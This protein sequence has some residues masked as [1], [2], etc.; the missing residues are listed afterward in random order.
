MNRKKQAKPEGLPIKSIS[1]LIGAGFSAPKG[2][3]VGST[4]NDLLLK[5]NADNFGFASCGSLI[6]ST[7]EGKKPSVGYKTSYDT[8]FEFCMDLIQYF[9]KKNGYFDYE[10]FYDFFRYDAI[11]DS[12]VGKVAESYLWHS[13]LEQLLFSLKNIYTQL[14]AYYLKDGKGKKWYDDEPYSM[15][16]GYCEGYTGILKYLHQL[17]KEYIIN[18][19]SLNHDLLFESFA[20]TEFMAGEFCDGFEQLGSPYY[21]ALNHDGRTYHVRLERYTGKYDKRFRLHKLHGSRDY[22]VYHSSDGSL[23]VPENYIKTR[24]GIGFGELY[25]EIKNKEGNLTYEECWIN[26]HADF[27]TGTT[28]KIARYNE[29]LFYKNMFQ[30]FTSN[31]QEAEHLLIIGYGGKDSEVNRIIL[32]NFDYG[33][34]RTYIVDPY[35]GEQVK[36]LAVQ[37]NAKLISKKLHELVEGDFK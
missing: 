18:V 1:L 27:L 22:G 8:E 12:E 35:A 33:S 32:E 15:G 7:Q 29:P 21:G 28:S 14:I 34:K 19:H 37:L 30:K 17:S 2:Y 9:N 16:L 20:R 23:A 36:I 13:N 31:L 24:Y 26:Y 11:K 5:C 3:P 10:E 4:L 25:K 6:V